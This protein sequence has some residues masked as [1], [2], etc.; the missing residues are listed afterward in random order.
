MDIYIV[1][2]IYISTL[3]ITSLIVIRVKKNIMLSKVS[4]KPSVP[5]IKSGKIV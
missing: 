2:A 1:I 3:I 5:T 4:V